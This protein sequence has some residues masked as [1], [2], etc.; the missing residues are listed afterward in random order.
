M[1]K[2]KVLLWGCSLKTRDIIS[3]ELLENC[4]IVAILDKNRSINEFL[5]YK[6]LNPDIL[7]N[8]FLEE[9]CIDYVIISNQYYT[10]ILNSCIKNKIDWNKLVICENVIE[11]LLYERYEPIKYLS[12]RMWNTQKNQQWQL[13]KLLEKDVIAD[14]TLLS[15]PRFATYIYKQD[16]FRFRTF[17][18]CAELINSENIPGDVAEF[19]VF[20]GDFAALIN[21]AFPDR[22]LHLFD[23]FEGFAKEEIASEIEKGRVSK[24][25][26]DP[27]ANTTIDVVKSRMENLDKVTIYKGY[28]PQSIPE[29]IY[30]KTFAFVSLDVDL[31]ESTYAGLEF[32]YPRIPEGGIIFIHDYQSLGGIKKAINRYEAQIGHRL[33]KVPLADRSGTIVITK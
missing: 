6:V 5:G 32:F 7:T 29:N 11:P 10:E 8:Q 23:S 16:Y 15:Q 4:D 17:E 3:K 27:F 30:N 26:A 21:R 13:I 2:Y 33:R 14:R 25:W 31:E 1:E 9:N 18:V 12:P 28:F 19:G 20:T 24:E 22:N